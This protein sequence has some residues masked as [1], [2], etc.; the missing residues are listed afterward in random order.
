MERRTFLGTGLA[1][2][3]GLGRAADARP[4]NVHRQVLDLAARQEEAR[5]ARFA[6]VTTKADLTA[7]QTSLRDK[8]LKLIGG[9]PE[10]K[11]PPP[12]TVV[13]A[14]D[15]DGYRIEKLVF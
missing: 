8:F 2:A 1:A 6:A 12:A 7:L 10:A 14:I 4:A 15:A 9:L 13:A 5:R 11:G 3:A